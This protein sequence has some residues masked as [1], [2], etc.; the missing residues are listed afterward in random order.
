MLFLSSMKTIGSPLT[1]TR[2][3]GRRQDTRPCTHICETAVKGVVLWVLKVHQF[4]EIKVG[5]A[6]AAE[7]D[8]D[9]VADLI[10]VRVID[11]GHF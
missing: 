9:A 2:T 4:H 5:F 6:V 7:R 3:S 10:V 11:G 1:K 8:L